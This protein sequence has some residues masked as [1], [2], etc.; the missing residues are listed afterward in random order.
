GKDIDISKYQ[1][2]DRRGDTQ[3]SFPSG[4]RIGASGFYLLERGD[5]ALPNISADIVFTGS[6]ANQDEGLRLFDG[7]CNLLD[8]AVTGS[9][10]PAGNN[11]TKHTMERAPDFS[12]Y[13]SA[14]VGGTPRAV[15]TPF[16]ARKVQEKVLDEDLEEEEKDGVS[17]NEDSGEVGGGN[18]DALLAD[19]GSAASSGGSSRPVQQCSFETSLVPTN[20]GARINEVAWMGGVRS[21]NDEWI[22]L[23]NTSGGRLDISGWQVVDKGQQIRVLFK[24]GAVLPAGGFYLL[25]RTDD[26]SVLGISADAIYAGGLSNSD[27]GLRLFDGNCRLIDEVLAAP[28]WPAGDNSSKGTMERKNDLSWQTS[29]VQGGTPRAENTVIQPSAGGSPT[30]P[31]SPSQSSSTSTP[32]SEESLATSSARSVFVSEFQVA[33]EENAKYEFVELYNA[34]SSA[35]DLSG[36]DLKKRTSGGSFSNL[37][38]NISSSTCDSISAPAIPARGYFLIASGEYNGNVEPDCRY[39]PSASGLAGSNN[40]VVLI[41]GDDEIIDEVFYESLADDVAYERNALS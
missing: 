32:P 39:V 40:S 3:I 4:S 36:W 16:V 8:E 10:W 26:D 13:T 14:N 22:E 9:S 17:R 6:I 28:S 20:Q 38:T 5:G 35:I 12:W 34:G 21:A 11:A 24:E 37:V 18:S 25:E 41:G 31:S 15:N 1:I 33:S 7:G 2:V 23:K 27:E 29:G 19:L 30:S